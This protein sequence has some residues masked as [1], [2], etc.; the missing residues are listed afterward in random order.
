MKQ[1]VI[2]SEIILKFISENAETKIYRKTAL[3]KNDN[4]KKYIEIC[5]VAA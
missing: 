3:S 1:A 2:L 5:K 4:I